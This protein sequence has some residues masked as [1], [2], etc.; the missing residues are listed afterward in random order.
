MGRELTQ[1]FVKILNRCSMRKNRGFT[2]MELV[3]T[4]TIL[5][6]LAGLSVPLFGRAA[7]QARRNEA[8][9]I[10]NIIHA[11]ERIYLLNNNTY[12]VPNGNPPS[13]QSVNDALNIDIILRDYTL[14]AMTGDATTYSATLS[15]GGNNIRIDQTGTIT[16]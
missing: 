13:V 8:I 7:D 16:G 2:L 12:W 6:A 9:T 11:G 1:A 3:V 14:S 10:L 4:L 5:A 15:R